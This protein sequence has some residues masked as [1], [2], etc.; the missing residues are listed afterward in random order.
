MKLAT[1]DPL[2]LEETKIKNERPFVWQVVVYDDPVNL[3]SYVTLVFQKIFGWSKQHAE[4]QMLEVHTK[5]RS[6]VWVGPREE[7]ELYVE[8]LH[9]FLL[10]AL[11]E[12]VV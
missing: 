9:G 11:L 1:A 10:T 6:I 12:K 5:G 7:A 8:K 3:M 2:V 4:K